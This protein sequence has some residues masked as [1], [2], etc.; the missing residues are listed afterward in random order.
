MQT[1]GSWN[2]ICAQTVGSQFE[3]PGNFIRF[4]PTS[5]EDMHLFVSLNAFVLIGLLIGMSVSSSSQCC[6]LCISNVNVHVLGFPWPGGGSGQSKILA[7]RT[8]IRTLGHKRRRSGQLCKPHGDD[9]GKQT[10]RTRVAPIFFWKNN[11]VWKEQ[12][13]FTSEFFFF[14][15][16]PHIWCCAREM[17][18]DNKK[19]TNLKPCRTGY[20][21]SDDITNRHEKHVKAPNWDRTW[22]TRTALQMMAHFFHALQSNVRYREAMRWKIACVQIECCTCHLSA[23]QKSNPLLTF[24]GFACQK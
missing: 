14:F 12:H 10:T 3:L 4:A 18:Q 8:K 15:L 13:P 24:D 21:L 16:R 1:N 6:T 11:C 23:K 17:K 20:L 22:L 19:Q 7:A 9:S 5:I 2:Q